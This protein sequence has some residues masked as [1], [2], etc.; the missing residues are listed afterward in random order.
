MIKSREPPY[1]GTVVSAE[2]TLS[3]IQEMLLQYGCEAV[4]VTRMA[5]GRVQIRFVIEVEVQGV[6]R[7]IAISLEPPLL[8]TTKGRGYSKV[9]VANPA[10]SMRLAY[11]YLKSKLEAISY[12]LVSAEREFFSQVM[13]SLPDGSQGTVGDLAEQSILKGGDMYLPG[14]TIGKHPALAVPKESEGR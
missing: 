9:H 11:W 14:V 3:Q 5:D 13:V 10:R 12:G 6:Q 2:R 1:E 4:Q 8:A 7:K